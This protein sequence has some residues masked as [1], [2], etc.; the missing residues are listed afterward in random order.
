MHY[1]PIYLKRGGEE[2]NMKSD[3]CQWQWHVLNYFQE[4]RPDLFENVYVTCTQ[5]TATYFPNT[6]SCDATQ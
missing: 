1:K 5:I 6:S 4:N 3:D 2:L